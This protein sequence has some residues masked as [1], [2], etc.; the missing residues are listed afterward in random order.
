MTPDVEQR[1][2]AWVA[3]YE[4]TDQ[5]GISINSAVL[6]LAE[7]DKLRGEV[8]RL[9]KIEIRLRE[10]LGG[11][12]RSMVISL[13]YHLNDW[14][15]LVEPEKLPSLDE[16]LGLLKHPYLQE[17]DRHGQQIPTKVRMLET[18]TSDLPGLI[19]NRIAAEQGRVYR[20]TVNPLGAVSVQ[21]EDG[22]P[23]GVKPGE[24]EVVEWSD[25][26]G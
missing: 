19:S 2:R 26:N 3:R 25:R 23:L 1:L 11:D 10:F 5:G 13:V 22:K 8:D 6:L 17:S 12:A 9:Q 4:G 14:V 18:V 24:F 15:D 16:I 20:C 21:L 7:I